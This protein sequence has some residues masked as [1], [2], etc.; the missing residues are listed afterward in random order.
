VARANIAEWWAHSRDHASGHQLHF[1][2]DEARIKRGDGIHTPIISTVLFV[3]A[4]VGGPTLVMDQ[5]VVQERGLAESGALVYPKPNRLAMFDGS[6]LH[7]K[8]VLGHSHEY[9]APTDVSMATG[10]LP[11]RGPSPV[12]Q[13]KRTT[14][15]VG[16]WESM[17]SRPFNGECPGPGMRMPS[18]DD[19]VQWPRLFGPQG[20]LAP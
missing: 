4:E 15:M 10:V 14:F 16:F 6:L 11:G 13:G 9:P 18:D 12:P 5:S 1:D 7:G 3:S 2:T 20:E 17:E 19:G 8:V